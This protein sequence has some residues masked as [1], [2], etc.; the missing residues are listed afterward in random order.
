ME[1]R[2]SDTFC[3]L[4]L[5]CDSEIVRVDLAVDSPPRRPTTDS[6]LGPTLDPLELA[7]RKLLALFDRA[8]PRDFADVYRIAKR[9]DRDA[10]IA[11][12]NEIDP[13][14]DLAYLALALDR[15]Q[16]LRD[17]ELPV[18]ETEVLELRH[19][20]ATWS[21]QIRSDGTSTE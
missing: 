15:A 21:E 2:T 5:T 6:S 9:F 13:G 10:F 14:F 18:D 17:H 20:L 8:A 11:M 3:R 7:G 19:W 12:A 1:V 4:E 16:R